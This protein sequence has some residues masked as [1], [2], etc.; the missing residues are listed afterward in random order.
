MVE[1][2]RTPAVNRNC[3]SCVGSGVDFCMAKQKGLYLLYE[4]YNQ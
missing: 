1:A 2:L 3:P 4:A